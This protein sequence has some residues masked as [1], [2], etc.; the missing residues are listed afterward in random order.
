MTRSL[1]P[2]SRIFGLTISPLT[3]TEVV[4]YLLA[5]PRA[6]TAGPGLIVT[7]NIQHIALLRQDPALR[8]A[9]DQAEIILC[10]GFP[11]YYYARLRGCQVPGRVTGCDVVAA[12]FASPDRLRHTRLFCVVDRPETV[13][14]LEN[15]AVRHGLSDRIATAIPPFG[16]EQ[17]AATCQALAET[18]RA[19]ETT[20]LLMG[21][22]APRSE[23]FVAEARSLLPPCWALCIGQAIKIALG[24]TPRPPRLVQRLNLEWL[25]RLGLEPGRMS[26]RYLYSLFGFLAAIGEDLSHPRR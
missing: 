2:S 22:G 21:V 20:L 11:V 17:D 8:A 5:T 1:S 12:L 23:R 15:W 7:P 26:Q 13:T 9:C 25:W 19:H 14:A 24:L 10:D 3:A 18:I 16:F 4:D 6:E